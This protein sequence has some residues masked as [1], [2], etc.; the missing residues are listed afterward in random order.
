METRP[1]VRALAAL[2]EEGDDGNVLIVSRGPAFFVCRAARGDRSILVEAAASANLPKGHGLSPSKVGHLRAAGFASRP[3]HKALAKH[4]VL[5]AT[6]AFDVI[7]DMIH[8][9]FAEVYG[10][11]DTADHVD[12][13]PGPADRTENPVLVDAMQTMAKKREHRYRAALY[14]ALLDAKLLVLVDPEGA[15]HLPEKNVDTAPFKV[16]ELMGFDVYAA[17]TSLAALRRYDQRGRPYK[18]VPG[19]ALFAQL[20]EYNVGSLLL[21]PRSSVGGEL[22][23]NELETLAGASFR[24]GRR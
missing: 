18:R 14:R 9:L 11:S 20:L 4:C 2:V 13:Q 3:G 10:Q 24:R 16:D 8:N 1:L 7:A 19:R 6:G 22:Y 17:F 21:D 5:D 12:L 23:R 15:D